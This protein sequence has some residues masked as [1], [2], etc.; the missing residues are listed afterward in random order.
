MGK[1]REALRR[2][3]ALYQ[4]GKAALALIGFGAGFV[5]GHMT[6]WSEGG[7]FQAAPYVGPEAVPGGCHPAGTGT[8]P[9]RWRKPKTFSS[10]R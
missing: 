6:A 1:N 4:I 3:Q 5:Y 10:T 8:A 9:E 7:S 2:R